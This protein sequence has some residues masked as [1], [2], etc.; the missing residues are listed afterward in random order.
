MKS[1]SKSKSKYLSV[2][3]KKQHKKSVRKP[4]KDKLYIVQRLVDVKVEDGKKLYLVKWKSFP[5]RVNTWEPE[6]L[7]N[8]TCSESVDVFNKKR[9]EKAKKLFEKLKCKFDDGS[10][11]RNFLLYFFAFQ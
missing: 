4:P 6:E 11:M 9:D 10:S 8:E 2:A 7:L 3:P 1:K 5:N